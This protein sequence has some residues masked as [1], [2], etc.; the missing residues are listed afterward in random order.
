MTLYRVGIAIFSCIEKE[1]VEK[2]FDETLF[3]IRN[4][5]FKLNSEMLL[6]AILTS[7]L[8][9][10]VLIKKY[11]KSIEEIGSSKIPLTVH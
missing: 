10:E 11:A 3:L 5:T 2:D 9:H 1:I 7:K 8:S 6:K 4:C